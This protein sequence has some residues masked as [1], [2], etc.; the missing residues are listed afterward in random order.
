MEC[1]PDVDSSSPVLLSHLKHVHLL[2]RPP[3]V[4]A[5][6]PRSLLQAAA[7]VMRDGPLIVLGGA[8]VLRD[9]RVLV[10]PVV[11][12]PHLLGVVQE[13]PGKQRLH[14]KTHEGSHFTHCARS[15]PHA[16]HH[17]RARRKKSFCWHKKKRKKK[18]IFKNVI[19][20]KRPDS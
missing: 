3:T 9:S 14:L 16:S 12:A 10:V 13:L 4:C 19:Q 7:V 2:P 15:H 18:S 20:K 8:D 1:P 5:F 17:I 11:V 6:L